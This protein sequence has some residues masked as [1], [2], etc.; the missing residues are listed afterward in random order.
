MNDTLQAMSVAYG[1]SWI[2]GLLVG[3]AFFVVAVTI[4]RKASPRA[5]L[6]ISLGIATG[7]VLGCASPLVTMGVGRFAEGGAEGFA[8]AQA[9][10]SLVGAILGAAGHV[11]VIMGVVTLARPPRRDARD[12]D[13]S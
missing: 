3:C 11:L 1:I 9:I 13:V 4:V 7:L 5:S 10:M 8:R 2:L 6:L 12:P